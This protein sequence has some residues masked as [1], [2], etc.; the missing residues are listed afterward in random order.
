MIGQRL[1]D[2]SQYLALFHTNDAVK[3]IIF[4]SICDILEF[5]GKASQFLNAGG[6]GDTRL[7]RWIQEYD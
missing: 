4:K 7:T 1:S 6:K 3:D 2:I 5:H